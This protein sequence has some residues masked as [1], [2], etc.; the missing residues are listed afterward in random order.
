MLEILALEFL[1]HAIRVMLGEFFLHAIALTNAGMPAMF[2]AIL[3]LDT[4]LIGG[5]FFFWLEF[6]GARTG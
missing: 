5:E 2:Q 4:F 6:F 3:R 1:L